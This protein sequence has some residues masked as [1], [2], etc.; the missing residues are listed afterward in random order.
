MNGVVETLAHTWAVRSTRFLMIVLAGWVSFRLIILLATA[1]GDVPDMGLQP[2]PYIVLISERLPS[3]A[4][5]I[6]Q[7]S[8]ADRE[9]RQVR[10]LGRKPASRLSHVDGAL[11]KQ[12][13][14]SWRATGK[15]D[16]ASGYF[17]RLAQTPDLPKRHKDVH[18]QR[19]ALMALFLHPSSFASRPLR[20][21]GHSAA[22]RIPL[23]PTAMPPSAR[24]PVSD[25]DHWSASAWVFARG[26][27]AP[28][29]AAAAPAG[30]LGGSQA[31]LKLAYRLK[32]ALP[33]AVFARAS[34]PLRGHDGREVAIGAEIPL[35]R[36]PVR[37]AVERRQSVSR[38]GTNAFAAYAAGG[39]SAVK[40]PG[41][42]RLDAYGQAGVVAAGG[43]RAF[44][45]GAVSALRPVAQVGPHSVLAGG[46]VSGA[47]QPDLARLDVGV[48]LTVRPATQ[49]GY[50]S[51]SLDWRERVAGDANPGSG[52]ALT[53]ASDF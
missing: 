26:T 47:V 39:T 14:Q 7:V 2:S 4:D 20:G 52:L 42:F 9:P 48:R 29:N 13:T 46:V 40:L 21:I 35:G 6:A 28:G 37:L 50:H 30:Q 45:D 36:W 51:L 53:L 31:G 10:P 27:T 3:P 15:T 12:A 24:P 41:R 38:N 25:E 5:E 44:A 19:V 43:G 32:P 16:A 33:I 22:G 17:V 11:V 18:G 1:E 23:L 49:T 34:A 8:M